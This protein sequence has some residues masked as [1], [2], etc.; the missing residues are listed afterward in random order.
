MGC[1]K[2]ADPLRDKAVLELLYGCGL[3]I[4]ELVVLR[5]EDIDFAER[6]VRVRGKGNKERMIP[7]GKM[8]IK[9]L[10]NWRDSCQMGIFLFTGEEGSHL[11]VRTVGRIVDRAAKRAG[12]SGVTPHMLRHSFATHMLEGGASIRVV[13]ELLGHESLITTQ[14]YLT[15]TAE[16]LKQ[17]YIEAFPRTRGDD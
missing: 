1:A 11:T 14:R 9:A 2:S 13:Q 5:W 17:S 4:G 8:A 12:L 10:Y 6:W 15:V 16:H 3:R 7:V